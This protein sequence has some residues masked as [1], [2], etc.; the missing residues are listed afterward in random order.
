MRRH[1]DIGMP[2]CAAL[3]NLAATH[4]VAVVAQ[5]GVEVLLAAMRRHLADEDVQDC[6]CTALVYLTTGSAANR[7]AIAARGGVEVID[8]AMRQHPT[9]ASVQEQGDR[10]R[11]HLI[12]APPDI[13]PPRIH[14]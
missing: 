3:C 4:G 11:R 8:A 9:A 12:G 10:A 5:G 6:G 1:P 7:A 13:P 14:V 2:G